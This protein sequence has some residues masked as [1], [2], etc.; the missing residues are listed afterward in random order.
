MYNHVA[1]S[2]HRLSPFWYSSASRMIVPSISFSFYPFVRELDVVHMLGVNVLLECRV[3]VVVY[4]RML[5]SAIIKSS[6]SCISVGVELLMHGDA[7]TQACLGTPIR[8]LSHVTSEITAEDKQEKS[9][10]QANKAWTRTKAL[11][12]WTC[13]CRVVHAGYRDITTLFVQTTYR[14]QCGM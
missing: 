3:L 14:L 4:L 9:W 10:A 2:K 12:Y 7:G 1:P 13:A 6:W 5:L 8:N 11:C